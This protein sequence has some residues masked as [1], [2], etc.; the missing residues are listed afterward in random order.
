MEQTINVIRE[1]TEKQIELEKEPILFGGEGTL[2]ITDDGLY[3]VKDYANVNVD[4][5]DGG[6]EITEEGITDVTHYERAN[7]KVT[8]GTIEI[9]ENGIVDVAQYA[10]A[11]VNV[12]PPQQEA[13][14]IYVRPSTNVGTLTI[15]NP[16]GI[17]YDTVIVASLEDNAGNLFGGMRQ[18]VTTTMPLAYGSSPNWS[19]LMIT[20]RV[21]VTVTAQQI[22]IESSGHIYSG[23][24][25]GKLYAIT[26]YKTPNN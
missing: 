6:I 16:T 24:K 8:S 2:D 15:D 4:V 9:T 11:N 10:S 7:V 14:T 23:Y 21:S 20:N 19:Y 1:F 5:V 18:G 17:L 25:A 12:Q 26:L 13:L 22:S 3:N